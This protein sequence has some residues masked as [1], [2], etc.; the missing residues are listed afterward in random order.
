MWV[1]TTHKVL[2]WY[3]AERISSRSRVDRMSQASYDDQVNVDDGVVS[4]GKARESSLEEM[5]LMRYAS[6]LAEPPFE[7]LP[8]KE[9]YEELPAY[10]EEPQEFAE[11]LLEMVEEETLNPDIYEP[12]VTFAPEDEIEA[13]Q[14]DVKVPDSYEE[15]SI[16]VE[17]PEAYEPI[18]EEAPP[19]VEVV[20]APPPKI[21]SSSDE[22]VENLRRLREDVGQ[23]SELSSEEGNIVGAFSAAFFQFM[24]PLAKTVPVDTSVL[25]SEFRGVERANVLP[26]GELVVLMADGRMQSID[27]KETDKRDLLVLLIN[28]VMPRFNSLVSDKREKIERRITFLAD[29]TRELQ[30]IA[31]SFAMI[32]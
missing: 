24:K 31:E 11:P 29:V 3:Y 25:S 2:S 23:I 20:D 18:V 15:V 12:E 7:E 22:V 1:P 8:P 16:E 14:P 5:I 4:S 19:P 10:H 17:E 9:E 13:Y 28:D 6:R 32:S 21:P 27:L 30:T 26:T